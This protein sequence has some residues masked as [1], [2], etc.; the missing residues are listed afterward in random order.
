MKIDP[1]L[2]DFKKFIK[3]PLINNN[4]IKVDIFTA[5]F[6]FKTKIVDFSDIKTDIITEQKALNIN[7]IILIKK[8]NK[9]IKSFFK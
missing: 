5:K 9:L 8:I 3:D 6:F 4:I 1:Y 7:P 2:L